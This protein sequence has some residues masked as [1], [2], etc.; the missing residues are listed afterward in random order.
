MILLP[1]TRQEAR[2]IINEII[3]HIPDNLRDGYTSLPEIKQILM[4]TQ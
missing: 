3:E 1:S 2:Y 4:M